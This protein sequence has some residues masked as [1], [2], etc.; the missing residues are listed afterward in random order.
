[1]AYAP[2]QYHL[3]VRNR[4]FHAQ[5]ECVTELQFIVDAGFSHVGILDKT[6][7]IEKARCAQANVGSIN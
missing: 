6:D 2:K 5:V 7:L 1:M 3:Y 4:D